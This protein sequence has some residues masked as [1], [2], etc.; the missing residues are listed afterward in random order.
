[1]PLCIAAVELPVEGIVV[2]G[3]LVAGVTVDDLSVGT[4]VELV[5]E[6]LFSD[7]DA[8]HLVWKWRPIGWT[9]PSAEITGAN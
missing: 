9:E 4:E 5:V 7:D 2:M 8:D 3:Q 6:P 1:M